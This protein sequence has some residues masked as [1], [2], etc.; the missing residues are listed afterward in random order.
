MTLK[1]TRALTPTTGSLYY[2]DHPWTLKEQGIGTS[3]GTSETL[4]VISVQGAG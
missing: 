4:R 3:P 1:L 2:R